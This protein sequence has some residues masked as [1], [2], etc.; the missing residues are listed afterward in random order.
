MDGGKQ[1]RTKIFTPLLFSCYCL[2]CIKIVPGQ[3]FIEDILLEIPYQAY[4][5]DIFRKSDVEFLGSP[6][7]LQVVERNPMRRLFDH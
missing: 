3:Y 4:F 6:L 5:N 1:K 7:L 2:V